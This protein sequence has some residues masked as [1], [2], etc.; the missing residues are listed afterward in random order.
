MTM[1]AQLG[2][3]TSKTLVTFSTAAFT[4]L[5]PLQQAIYT[6]LAATDFYRDNEVR[7]CIEKMLGYWRANA[8]WLQLLIVLNPI[9]LRVPLGGGQGQITNVPAVANIQAGDV[10]MGVGANT[11]LLSSEIVWDTFIFI[12]DSMWEKKRIY[13]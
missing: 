5:G 9:Y 12:R 3:S 13:I 8:G 1:Q 7:G 10:A 4:N 2:Y 11:P 6:N